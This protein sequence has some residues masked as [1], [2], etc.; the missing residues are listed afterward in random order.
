MD[1][2]LIIDRKFIWKQM[3]LCRCHSETANSN[4]HFLFKNHAV[5]LRRAFRRD[6]DYLQR[7][8]CNA[9]VFLGKHPLV[10]NYSKGQIDNRYLPLELLQ[11]PLIT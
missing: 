5:F 7:L 1:Q 4:A 9:G 10:S 8:A 11:I 2:R 6:L 3:A